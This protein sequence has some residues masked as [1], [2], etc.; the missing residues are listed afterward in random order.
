MF[1]HVIEKHGSKEREIGPPCQDFEIQRRWALYLKF[2]YPAVTILLR[3][4]EGIY[5]LLTSTDS[6]RKMMRQCVEEEQA[7]AELMFSFDR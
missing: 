3:D 6:E 4:S 2:K 1:Y 7:V 5:H